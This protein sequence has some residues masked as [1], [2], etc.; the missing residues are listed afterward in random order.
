VTAASTS[1]VSAAA[2]RNSCVDSRLSV[3][4]SRTKGPALW[5]VFQTV[6][7]E[8]ITSAVDAPRGPKRSAAQISTGKTMYGTS[9]WEGSSASSTS[10]VSIAAPSISSRRRSGA[11]ARLAQVSSSGVTTSAP[12]KSDSHHV[13]QTSPSSPAEM[14]FPKRSESGPKHALIRVPAAHAATSARTSPTRSI[15]GRRPASRRRRTAP[16]TTSSV[17]PT[18]WPRTVPSGVE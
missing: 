15:A 9:R 13:R 14:T 7:P 1:D 4:D 2:A 11:N 10:A 3:I 12:Q 16:T 6:R 18:V 5:A 8:T 17:F